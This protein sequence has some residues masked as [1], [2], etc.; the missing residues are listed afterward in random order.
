VNLEGLDSPAIAEA[1]LT[2]TS[3]F[4]TAIGHEQDTPLIQKVADKS[5]ITPTAFGQYLND[6]YNN[7]VHQLENSRAKLVD[8]VRKQ[9]EANYSKQIQNL[10]EKALNE[11]EL[12]NK[13]LM[14]LQQQLKHER[15]EK[16]AINNKI[17]ELERK[18]A[19]QSKVP[20]YVWILIAVIALVLGWFIGKI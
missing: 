12:K 10:N 11:Q 14:L 4:V 6:A 3:P 9:L 19:S 8:D 20:M 13:E 7:T 18:V 5:F 17:Q 16:T 15:D 2:L 1:S